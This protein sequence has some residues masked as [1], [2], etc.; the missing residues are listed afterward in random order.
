MEKQ[1]VFDKEKL[2]WHILITVFL[3]LFRVGVEPLQRT[4]PEKST[5]TLAAAAAQ[6]PWASATR[7]G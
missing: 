4:L 7:T 1:D 2:M 6:T 5:S 3:S